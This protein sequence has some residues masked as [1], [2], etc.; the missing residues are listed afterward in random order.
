MELNEKST[1][2]S[3][4]RLMGMVYAYKKGELKLDKLN[5]S[6][7]DKIKS[8]ANGGKTKDGE[9]TKGMTLKAAKDYAK[10]K[11]EGLP[12]KVEEQNIISFADFT[13]ESI[14]KEKE[15]GKQDAALWHQIQVAKKT[16][17]YSDIG[18][19]IMG[20]MTKDEARELLKKH[21]IKFNENVEDL[22]NNNSDM[23]DTLKLFGDFINENK[24]TKNWVA[25]CYDKKDK[26]IKQWDIKD[27]TEHE[28]SKE[29][30]ANLPEKTDDWSLMP[31]DFWKSIRSKSKKQK[32]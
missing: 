7:A 24:E 1:S 10:T 32:L 14:K 11:H 26:I 2:K 18:A 17:K 4:Q 22:K 23:S 5:K 27:R 9:K 30:E 6:L 15:I 3:Q 12:E 19:T 21:G 31:E 25:T 28:A 20:G 29:A 13:N 8:I 16:L